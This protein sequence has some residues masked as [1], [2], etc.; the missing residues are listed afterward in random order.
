M[1]P[2]PS[3]CGVA[4]GGVACG[5]FDARQIKVDCVNSADS[6]CGLLSDAAATQWGLIMITNPPELHGLFSFVNWPLSREPFLFFDL[7]FTVG[8]LSQL[9][10]STKL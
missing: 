10:D 9:D 7:Q 2:T 4:G 3:W 6:K 8:Q 1:S 5:T